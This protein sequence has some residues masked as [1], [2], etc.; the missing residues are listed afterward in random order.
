VKVWRG[1]KGEEEGEDWGEVEE[2]GKEEERRLDKFPLS[3]I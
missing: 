3:R 2:E 1:R